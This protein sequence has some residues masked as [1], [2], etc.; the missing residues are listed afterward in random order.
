[1]QKAYFHNGKSINRNINTKKL[2]LIRNI[3]RKK[4]VDINKLLNRVKI[5]QRKDTKKKIIFYSFTVVALSI[6]G[7]LITILK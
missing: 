4:V 3:D 7:S 2:P 5:D 6:F 1:M